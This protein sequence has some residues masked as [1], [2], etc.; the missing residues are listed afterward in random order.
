MGEP[1]PVT[2][3]AVTAAAVARP[4]DAALERIE[5]QGTRG[6]AGGTIWRF[7]LGG[8]LPVD[9][10]EPAWAAGQAVFEAT[11][12]TADDEDGPWSRRG[13]GLFYRLRTD[14]GPITS[15]PVAVDTRGA[16]WLRLRIEGAAPQVSPTLAARARMPVLHFAADGPGPYR[17][18]VGSA[19]A[20]PAD[21]RAVSRMLETL[22]Q[23]PEL[24]AGARLGEARVLAGEAARRPEAGLSMSAVLWGVLVLGVA[25]L[26]LML[27][28]LLREARQG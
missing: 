22:A 17:L 19:R 15:E 27:R 25:L 26:A 5:L 16:R 20:E 12:E 13:R 4:S 11:I 21:E 3:R 6:D 18:A 10:L 1:L 7:E 28:S 23:A 9:A 14:A 24:V 2:L 8:P